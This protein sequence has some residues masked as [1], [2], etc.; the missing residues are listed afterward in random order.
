MQ[1][2]LVEKALVCELVK[3]DGLP[4]HDLHQFQLSV[5]IFSVGR[6][7]GS[8]GQD[9]GEAKCGSRGDDP[10]DRRLHEPQIQFQAC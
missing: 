5:R 2:F 8:A 4:E 1:A 7:G 6:L 9:A 10:A 3:G